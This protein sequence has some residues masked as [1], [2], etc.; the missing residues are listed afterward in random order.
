MSPVQAARP[1]RLPSPDGQLGTV[2]IGP[3]TLESGA[4]LADVTIAIQRWGELSES[5]DNVVLVLHALTG[6]TH[7]AGPPDADHTN[8]GWWDGLVGPGQALDTNEWC[9]ISTNAL[10]GCGGTTGPSSIAPDGKPYGSRFPY[11]SIRDQ[12]AAEARALDLLGVRSVASVMG[13]SMGGARALEWAITHPDRVDSALVLAVGAR[14]TADQIGTQS[15]QIQ[16]ILADPNWQ[17]GDYYETGSFPT[18]GLGLARRFAHLAYR[19]ELELDNRF[20]NDGQGGEDP[21]AGGRYAVQSYLEHQANKLVARF[22]AGS[23]VVLTDSLNRHDVGYD[24]GGIE[25]ALGSCTVPTIVA[26]F[27][28]DRLY[29]IRLQEELAHG[30]PNCAG[31]RIIET[32]AGH[33]AFL[34]EFEAVGKLMTETMALARAARS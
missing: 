29:P 18:S 31:L 34:T 25:A 9:V 24:R 15:S 28:T 8:A 10:G 2:E 5:R 3:M 6:D 7:V 27:D 30:L 32:S 33:D 4:E 21:R 23:Y 12:V 20:R 14:A 26:G 17:G 16:A 22:D 13:G 11:V 1:A 19:A